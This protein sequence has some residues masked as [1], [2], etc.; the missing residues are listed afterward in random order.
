M[1]LVTHDYL[2]RD[3]SIAATAA[4]RA[5]DRAAKNRVNN[6]MPDNKGVGWRKKMNS[7]PKEPRPG[8]A[9]VTDDSSERRRHHGWRKT[10]QVSLP[11]TPVSGQ[12]SDEIE[13]AQC[14]RTE[15]ST[16]RGDSKPKLIRYTS[17]FSSFRDTK[18]AK[19]PN[20]AKPWDVAVLPIE[21]YVDPKVAI[22]SV[23]SHMLSFSMVP[24]PLGHNSSLFR[25]FEDY[26]KVR[27]EKDHLDTMLQETHQNLQSSGE[28]WTKD[29]RRYE[30]E[31]RRLELLIARGATGVAGQVCMFSKETATDCR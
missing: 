8:D 2:L 16:P 15:P 27:D 4:K 9:A 28:Q 18:E 22:Q 5:T 21:P 3:T 12:P 6:S 7:K 20:F 24:I 19:G 30:E 26:H 14:E 29:E 1:D 11:A 13:N 25:V 23:R 10:V 17:L 31:I